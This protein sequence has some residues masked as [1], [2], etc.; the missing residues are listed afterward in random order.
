MTD[1]KNIADM[2]PA[3]AA[4]AYAKKDIKV[5]PCNE[6][7]RPMVP[8]GLHAASSDS[9]LVTQWWRQHPQALIGMPTGDNG[10]GVGVIDLDNHDGKDGVGEFKRIC[11]G[12]R[13]ET[14]VVRT[15]SGGLHL[16]FTMPDGVRLKS[17]SNKIAPGVDTRGDGGYVIAPGSHLPD[18]RKYTVIRQTNPIEMPGWLVDVVRDAGCVKGQKVQIKRKSQKEPGV[19]TDAEEIKIRSALAALDPDTSY[20][21]WRDVGMALRSWDDSDDGRANAIWHEWSSKGDKYDP[22]D[23]DKHWSSYGS[24]GGITLG[25]LYHMAKDAGWDGLSGADKDRYDS[26]RHGV[27][28]QTVS[29][30]EKREP[31]DIPLRRGRDIADL[32][33][34]GLW[35]IDGIVPRH[36]LLLLT[37]D[38][39]A[40]KTLAALDLA[41]SLTHENRRWLSSREVCERGAVLYLSL[42]QDLRLTKRRTALLGGSPDAPIYFVDANDLPPMDQGG[43]ES[44]ANLVNSAEKAGTPVISIVVDVWADLSPA[45]V[46]RK[47]AY[48]ADSDSLRKLVMFAAEHDALMVL[49]HHTAKDG[50]VSGSMAML[51]KVT[52]SLKL[53][54]VPLPERQQQ[55]D[56]ELAKRVSVECTSRLGSPIDSFGV[57]FWFETEC[58]EGR[59]ILVYREDSQAA[60]AES[61]AGRIIAALSESVSSDVAMGVPDIVDVISDAGGRLSRGAV[62]K[63]LQR[64]SKEGVVSKVGRGVYYLSDPHEVAWSKTLPPPDWAVAIPTH[65][66]LSN[67]PKLVQVAEDKQLTFGQDFGQALD[68][69]TEAPTAS[70]ESELDTSTSHNALSKV[71]PKSCPDPSPYVTGSYLTF[72]QIP[73]GVCVV[74]ANTCPAAYVPGAGPGDPYYDAYIA[75]SEDPDWEPPEPDFE[76][77]FPGDPDSPLPLSVSSISEPLNGVFYIP[78]FSDPDCG[79]MFEELSWLGIMADAVSLLATA[80]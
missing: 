49:L 70:C 65:A 7:K 72:G 47:N 12:R 32:P 23:A 4:V 63:G 69:W 38:P 3:E 52:Q 39:K 77:V 66:P 25:T 13:L 58:D 36:G 71:C 18:G 79:P 16:W 20:D 78:V 56:F 5:M 55:G 28:V 11:N 21:S 54:V 1:K 6:K 57:D 34:S 51:G 48:L 15:P 44:L 41:I 42:D 45:V 60:R 67:C 33:E 14:T 53:S 59:K 29:R 30:L 73:E 26:M 75:P 37:A 8:N 40:G 19:P 10:N 64:L 61:T 74:D 46:S 76:F 17:T 62:Y 35:L 22:S 27:Q 80:A 24:D 68:D 2:T 31:R 9:R 43:M 50:T